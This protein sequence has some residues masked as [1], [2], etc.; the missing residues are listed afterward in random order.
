MPKGKKS[1]P[2]MTHLAQFR[3]SHPNMSLGDAMVAAKKTY[4]KPAR[5]AGAGFFDKPKHVPINPPIMKGGNAFKDAVIN[6]LKSYDTPFAKHVVK[7]LGGEQKG[8]S[9]YS[10]LKYG[11]GGVVGGGKQMS[12][13]TRSK[14]QQY[15]RGQ[16]KFSTMPV[17]PTGPAPALQKY[18]P[19]TAF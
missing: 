7:Q 1:N 3:K 18:I 14:L 8:G 9:L 10:L 17:K 13:S 19:G 11:I 2:W 15:M 12:P 5:Q 16:G 4:K 6:K